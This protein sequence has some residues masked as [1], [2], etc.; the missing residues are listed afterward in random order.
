L[1]ELRMEA[2]CISKA[3]AEVTAVL[4]KTLDTRRFQ[5][6]RYATDAVSG[7]GEITAR[8][9]VAGISDALDYGM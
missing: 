7:V 9:L 1:F 8:F 3:G 2:E 4:I 5:D 6:V